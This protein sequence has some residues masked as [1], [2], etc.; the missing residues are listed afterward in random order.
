[1]L[2]ARWIPEKT[3]EKEETDSNNQNPILYPRYRI[4]HCIETHN[5]DERNPQHDSPT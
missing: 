2:T 5:R 4:S 1:M 3:L